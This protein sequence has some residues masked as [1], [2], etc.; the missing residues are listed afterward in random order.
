MS[1]ELTLF[2]NRAYIEMPNSL[3]EWLG[4]S[5]LLLM[6]AGWLW[7]ELANRRRVAQSSP[8][9]PEQPAA[10]AVGALAVLLVLVSDRPL[11]W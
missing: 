8:A 5:V 3:I 2:G 1:I 7:S 10:A 6:V 9:Q 4:W 11:F